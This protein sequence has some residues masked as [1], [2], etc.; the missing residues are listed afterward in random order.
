[1][2][3]VDHASG[4]V[5]RRP[6]LDRLL[7]Q[8]RPGDTLVVWRLDR[9]GRSVRQLIELVADLEHR[10][11]GFRS[12]T[13]SIDTT[14][15]GGRVV[16]HVFAALAQ[17]EAELVSERT[18]AGLEAARARGRKGGRRTVMTEEKTAMARVMYDSK[19]HTVAAIAKNLGV[20]RSALYRALELSGGGRG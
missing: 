9:L 4:K 2:V 20:S 12:L 5:A 10:Q 13:E 19:E 1:M 11:V 17:M 14:T 16:F 18:L 7:G 15:S 8:V 3:F 6:E